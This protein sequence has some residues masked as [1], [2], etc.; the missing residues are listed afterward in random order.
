MIY[1]PHTPQRR[2]GFVVPL[3]KAIFGFAFVY[4][5]LTLLMLA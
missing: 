5:L 2:T 4:L 3:C 1:V